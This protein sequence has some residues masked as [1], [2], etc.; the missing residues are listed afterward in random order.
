VTHETHT[1]QDAIRYALRQHRTA[2]ISSDMETAQFWQDEL[3]R[4]R[5]HVAATPLRSA[6]Q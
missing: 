1:L 4:L 6:T 5:D 3:D 2:C